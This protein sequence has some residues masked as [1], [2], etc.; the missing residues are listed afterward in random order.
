MGPYLILL[1]FLVGF[2][3]LIVIYNEIRISK[4]YQLT[5]LEFAGILFSGTVVPFLFTS[6]SDVLSSDIA[7][8]SLSIG[9]TFI[10]AIA[11]FLRAEKKQ[12]T[13][14]FNI[15]MFGLLFPSFFSLYMMPIYHF[16]LF[17]FF[18]YPITLPFLLIFQLHNEE[19]LGKTFKDFRTDMVKTARRLI[20]NEE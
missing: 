15:I 12:H 3:V 2:F 18:L 19:Y 9:I 7:T 8:I 17:G 16:G 5:L 6:S 11:I 13:T 1:F 14:L 4:N 10:I 20:R